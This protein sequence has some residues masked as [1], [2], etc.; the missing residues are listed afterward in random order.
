MG[1]V[2]QMWWVPGQDIWWGDARGRRVTGSWEGDVGGKGDGTSP[3][4]PILE[5]T[6]LCG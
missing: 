2:Q 1:K 4:D 5:A 3:F 6:R